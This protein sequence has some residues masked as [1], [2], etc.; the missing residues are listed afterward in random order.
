MRYYSKLYCF[1]NSLYVRNLLS[2]YSTRKTV[3]NAN[4][5]ATKRDE[6]YMV[7]AKVLRW[8]PIATYIPLA[9]V[10]VLRWG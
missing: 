3:P 7:N 4:E 5:M 1:L 6:M 9:H 10:G 2:P 8:G